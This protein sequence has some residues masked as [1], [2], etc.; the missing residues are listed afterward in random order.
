MLAIER[1]PNTFPSIAAT[2]PAK[3][4]PYERTTKLS[5]LGKSGSSDR[6]INLSTN[7][8]KKPAEQTKPEAVS[9]FNDMNETSR[10]PHNTPTAALSG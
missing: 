7:Q 5:S 3:L 6:W 1:Q 2:I 9:K 8:G 4:S 10:V